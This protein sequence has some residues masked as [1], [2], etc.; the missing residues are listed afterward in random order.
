MK[1]LLL[2]LFS[3]VF[4]S[5]AQA[6][7]NSFGR[8]MAAG[9]STECTYVNPDGSG[10]GT[11][12]LA[13]GKMRMDMQVNENGATYP[14]HMIHDSQRMYSWG[15]PMGEGQGIIMPANMGGANPMGNSQQTNMDEEMDFTCSPWAGDP[16][17]FEPP[18]DVTFQDM[19]QLMAGMGL[20]TS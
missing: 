6:E 1:R 3:F 5:S 16:S 8:L 13:G 11:V 20:P 14:M 15:G 7:S 9:Q 12:H 10:S 4:V 19:S 2:V 17:Q 18:S